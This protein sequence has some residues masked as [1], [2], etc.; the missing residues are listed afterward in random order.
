MI[1]TGASADRIPQRYRP[2]LG[3]AIERIALA[4]PD[5]S[6]Y[7]YGSVA[8]GVAT[9][10]RSDIDLLAIGLPSDLARSLS[11]ELS[12]ECSAL[13][14]GVEISA[15]SIKDSDGESDEAH[16]NR[17]FLRHYCVLLAG[18]DCE[19]AGHDFRGDR[20]AARG[21]NGDISQHATEW[22]REAERVGVDAAALER[23]VARKALL[24]V[25]GLVSVHDS[26]W[27]T[28]RIRAAVRWAEIHPDLKPGLLAL[29]GWCDGQHQTDPGELEVLLDTTIDQVVQQFS[30]N[31]GL[32]PA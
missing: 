23:R 24:A 6:V 19:R 21:F 18:A 25:A 22:R 14:R 26:T 2:L 29:V 20:R 31:V 32:W 27:T 17:V 8:T 7:L 1:R 30:H 12:T 28:D 5:A 16:G 11:V 9:Q 10:P 4:A 13:C 15:A 3:A